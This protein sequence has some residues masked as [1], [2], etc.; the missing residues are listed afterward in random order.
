L[1]NNWDPDGVCEK[2][3]RGEIKERGE[4]E[5]SRVVRRDHL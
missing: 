3:P 2:K 5:K 1:K 4:G